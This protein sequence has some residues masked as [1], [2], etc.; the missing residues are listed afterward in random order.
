MIVLSLVVVRAFTTCNVYDE[1]LDGYYFNITELGVAA[2]MNDADAIDDL[3][4]S[5]CDVKY[6]ETG[7]DWMNLK[8]VY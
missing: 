1:Y 4:K 2:I 8:Y 3:V 5:G 7:M 6:N